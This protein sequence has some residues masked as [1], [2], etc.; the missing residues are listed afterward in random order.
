MGKTRKKMKIFRKE[1]EIDNNESLKNSRKYYSH[2]DLRAGSACPGN[3]T[4][5]GTPGNLPRTNSSNSLASQVSEISTGTSISQFSFSGSLTNRRHT[6]TTRGSSNRISRR[7][8]TKKN[9]DSNSSNRLSGMSFDGEIIPEDR[10]V[11]IPP[12]RSNSSVSD[13]PTIP[14]E[15]NFEEIVHIPKKSYS[16]VN[17]SQPE[18]RKAATLPRKTS[19]AKGVSREWH[20]EYPETYE[21]I[22]H[23]KKEVIRQNIILEIC[24]SHF[25]FYEDLIHVKKVYVRG[26]ELFGKLDSQTIASL[27]GNLNEVIQVNDG[28]EDEL[29][30]LRD[31]RGIINHIGGALRSWVP[32]LSC[33]AEYAKGLVLKRKRLEDCFKEEKVQAFLATAEQAKFARKLTIWSFLD[34]PR[35]NLPRLKL[36]LE[37]LLKHTPEGNE[38]LIILPEVISKLDEQIKKLNDSIA[39][40]EFQSIVSTLTFKNQTENNIPFGATQL[41]YKG[42][43]KFKHKDMELLLFDTCWAISRMKGKTEREIVKCEKLSTSNLLHPTRFESRLQMTRDGGQ[44]M[45][46]LAAQNPTDASTWADEFAKAKSRYLD[47][48]AEQSVFE[49]LHNGGDP[50]ND[51][52]DSINEV[53][54]VPKRLREAPKSERP[55]SWVSKFWSRSGDKSEPESPKV[56]RRKTIDVAGIFSSNDVTSIT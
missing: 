48:L 38:D 25:D 7:N 40:A 46:L 14:G 42:N 36:Q 18:K 45:L 4:Y 1:N 26:L 23:D 24:N 53:P 47:I 10:D 11:P 50:E 17:L 56:P 43:V 49:H 16:V 3:N 12:K 21:N 55:S 2:Q 39:A 22:K 20:K 37:R 41:F 33:Y 5:G 31:E 30:L 34:A 8:S 44:K 27:F 9:R 28:L 6:E 29:K 52:T 19:T 15:G 35:S 54:Q 32:K 51:E 13:L